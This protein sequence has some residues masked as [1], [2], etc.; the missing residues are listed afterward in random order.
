VSKYS[1]DRDRGV[2]ETGRVACRTWKCPTGY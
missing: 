1:N 2:E